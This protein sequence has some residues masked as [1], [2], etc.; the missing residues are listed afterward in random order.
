MAKETAHQLGTP[1]SSLVGWIE[2]LKDSDDP[3]GT[4][5]MVGTEIEKRYWPFEINRRPF[6]LK[7]VLSQKWKAQTLFNRC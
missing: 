1:L 4:S 5:Q 7:S 3:S 6:F 2:L